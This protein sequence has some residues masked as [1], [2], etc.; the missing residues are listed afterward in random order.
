MTIFLLLTSGEI[1]N[2]NYFQRFLLCSLCPSILNI[3]GRCY[4]KTDLL[5]SLPSNKVGIDTILI[6]GLFKAIEEKDK[7]KA[8]YFVFQIENENC[9]SLKPILKLFI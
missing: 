7:L 8:D 9:Q 6:N 1:M 5:G 2:W 3:L 4:K